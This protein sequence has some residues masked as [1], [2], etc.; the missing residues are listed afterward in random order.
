MVVTEK[1]YWTD[2][3]MKEFDARVISVQGNEVILDRTV[4]FAT[5]GGQP[6]DTGIL[7]NS[8]GDLK[9][10]DVKKAGDDVIHYVE[11]D[12][13]LEA[14]DSVHGVIDWQR[15]YAHM[16]HH[17]AVHVVDG[18]VAKRHGKEGLLTGGQLYEDRARIDL[19]IENFSRETMEKIIG[20][21][22]EFIREGHRIFQRELP[23][24]EALKMENLARTAPGREL[25]NSLEKVRLIVI[26]GL[27]EQADGG[28]H[29][30]YSREIG[31]IV[32]K[33][34]ESKGKRNKRVEFFLEE[35]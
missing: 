3:N 34:I 2:M 27:D 12:V 30:S 6:N 8:T 23:R 7:R 5:G 28:T 33:K 17:S 11:G 32:L 20:E 21:C 14:G 25:I 31:K 15:R 18:I 26:E 1:L 35:L 4:F 29:V 16:R 10:V 13:H 9:V 22:N 24:E 19:D